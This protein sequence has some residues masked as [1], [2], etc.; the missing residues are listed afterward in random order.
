MFRGETG[1]VM[2]DLCTSYCALYCICVIV[3]TSG[4]N[5]GAAAEVDAIT[6]EVFKDCIDD[7]AGLSTSTSMKAIHMSRVCMTHMHTH[8]ENKIKARDIKVESYC[9]LP[10]RL[11]YQECGGYL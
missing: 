3:I 1:L 8:G 2:R 10:C 6:S 7:H 4:C 9:S 11:P 5:W